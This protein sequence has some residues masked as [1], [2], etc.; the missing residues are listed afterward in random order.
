MKYWWAE[1]GKGKPLQ[2]SLHA[3]QIPVD[4]FWDGTWVSV[5]GFDRN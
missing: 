4:L 5:V 2:L 3:L 1:I